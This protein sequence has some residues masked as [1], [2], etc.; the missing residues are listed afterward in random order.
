MSPFDE[1]LAESVPA[2]AAAH[3]C[4]LG[5]R[6]RCARNLDGELFPER[7]D[8]AARRKIFRRIVSAELATPA[9]QNAFVFENEKLNS[10]Q[11]DF[12]AECHFA[13]PNFS[14][15]GGGTIV[16]RSRRAAL[17]IN[18]EDHWRMQTF[19]P[20]ADFDAAWNLM[21]RMRRELSDALP[22]AFSEKYG[23]FTACPTNLGTGIRVSVMLHLPALVMS[24]Q[25]E[26]IVRAS[27][28]AGL[29]VRGSAGEGSEPNG[30]IFQ[31]SNT[32]TLGIG[33]D[34]SLALVKRWTND[35]VEQ[36]NLAASVVINEKTAELCDRIARAYGILRHAVMLPENESRDLLSLLRLGGDL[37]FFPEETQNIFDELSVETGAAHL[38]LRAAFRG[39]ACGNDDD[40]RRARAR[41]FREAISAVRPPDFSRFNNL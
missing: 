32:H 17:T 11:R 5:V 41:L 6:V 15:A 25:M 22:F 33:S 39:K 13:P 28:A 10:S 14:V 3:S 36:E 35:V 1:F 19:A 2:P 7:L 4:A 18:E 24:G 40:V 37:S 31:F 16:S 20:G 23:F 30:C 27:E 8:L 21:A 38:A 12:L 34:E 29:T 26:K 9:F